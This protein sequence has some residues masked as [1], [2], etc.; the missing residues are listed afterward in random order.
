MVIVIGIVYDLHAI[1][2]RLLWAIDFCETLQ[3]SVGSGQLLM[4]LNNEQQESGK[5]G[6]LIIREGYLGR[7]WYTYTSD[8]P[9]G[10]TTNYFGPTVDC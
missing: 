10:H 5:M 1:R 3:L 6:T 9:R 4:Y 2:R 8:S 7:L